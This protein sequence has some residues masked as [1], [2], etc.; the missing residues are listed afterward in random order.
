MSTYIHFT[1]EQKKKANSVDLVDFLERQGEKLLRSGREKR[2]AS[3]RSITIRGNRWY[4]HETGGGGLAIDF[5]QNFYGHSF[6]E[7]VTRL[8]GEQGEI[9]YKTADI[10]EQ[11]ERKP[12]VLP[13][14]YS[15]M[16]RV[17]AYLIK[18]RCIDRDIISF[19]AR[20]K[21]LYESCEPSKDNTMEYHNA[22]FV[23]LDEKGIPRHGHKQGI[24]T[25]GKSFK[26]NIDSSNPCYSFNYI[27][28]SN[29]LYVFEAPI[30]MLS[31]ITI[32]QRDWQQ[33]S[34]VS[35]CGVSEQAM[36]KMIETN[37]HLS[38]VIL[39]LD[40]DKAGIETSEKFYDILT[41]REIKCD[42]LVPKYKDWN[43][44]V[45]ASYN[46]YASPPEEH[47]QYILR[48]EICV[49]I[50]SLTSELRNKDYSLLK[51]NKLF[52]NC[53]TSNTGQIVES[54]KQLS[55]FSLLAA[56]KEYIQIGAS[57]G[58]DAA[59]GRLYYGF[60]AYQNRSRLSNRLDM[61]GQELLKISKYQ[62]ILSETDKA[63]I[64]ESYEVIAQ[65]SL[66]AIILIEL[67]EQKQE[68]KQMKEMA[69]Q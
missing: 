65:H 32:Y 43:E 2:L 10:K 51:V 29:K 64:A 45:K 11:E 34:Y 66:K 23:G 35:L 22:V 12:F 15:D 44:D 36:I 18:Q 7:A 31:F 20:N 63:S 26:G 60:K 27:G 39:C 68:Q 69:M 9:I 5:L 14:K 25:R 19:F 52:H 54:L 59:K 49:E 4:D 24:Y 42:K 38:H 53:K 67:E 56:V 16:R 57:Q 8:L 37:P 50:Y 13:Q 55:A 61:I 1:D 21:M 41:A 48:D 6:P 17:F 46:L 30:D 62:G 28:K 47:P 58:I 3:D 33:H 40:H